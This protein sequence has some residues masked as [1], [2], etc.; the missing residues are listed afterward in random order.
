MNLYYT[1]RKSALLTDKEKKT[2]SLSKKAY[3][4]TLSCND[5]DEKNTI[6]SWMLP[7]FS[8]ATF[9]VSRKY[10]ARKQPVF[11]T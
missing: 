3:K 9:R 8:S 5:N 4:E 10:C 2:K 7:K 11:Y 6:D 1:I